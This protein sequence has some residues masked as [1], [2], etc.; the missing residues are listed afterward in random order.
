MKRTTMSQRAADC[1]RQFT[2]A[3]E[4]YSIDDSFLDLTEDQDIHRGGIEPCT[5]LYAVSCSGHKD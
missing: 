3:L 2:P 1:L 5:C 4:V